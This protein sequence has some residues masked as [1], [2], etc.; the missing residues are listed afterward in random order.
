MLA[1]VTLVFARDKSTLELKVGDEINACNCGEKCACK[2]MSMNAGKCTCDKDMVKAKTTGVKGGKA[3]LTAA[4][5]QK[6]RPFP[7]TGKYM[8]NCGPDCKCDTISQNPGK[9]TCGKEMKKVM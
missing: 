1:A 3:M 2:T 7:M 4:G 5:W 9:C 8:C 6:D